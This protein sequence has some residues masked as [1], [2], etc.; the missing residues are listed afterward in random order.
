MHIAVSNRACCFSQMHL[1]ILLPFAL[2]HLQAQVRVN[3]ILF[4]QHDEHFL[5]AS[6]LLGLPRAWQAF[7]HTPLPLFKVL[8]MVFRD[9]A[10]E[11]A[12]HASTPPALTPLSCLW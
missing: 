3:F 10:A 4:V 2:V 7:S 5:P 1:M 9:S 6:L 8:A 11:V 12:N